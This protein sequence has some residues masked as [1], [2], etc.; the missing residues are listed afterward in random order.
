MSGF[1]QFY[2]EIKPAAIRQPDIT[3]NKSR[4]LCSAKL[5]CLLKCKRCFN[6][7]AFSEELEAHCSVKAS[8]ILYK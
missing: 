7:I 2:A 5:T 4:H 3:Y 8:V 6:F 1:P